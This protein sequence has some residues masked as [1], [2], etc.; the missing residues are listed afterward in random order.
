[1]RRPMRFAVLALLIPYWGVSLAT[2]QA[3][4]TRPSISEEISPVEELS[5][6]THEGQT[7]LGV[8][9]RPPGQRLFPA[10]VI[11][12]SP[13][14]TEAKDGVVG[15]MNRLKVRAL[16]S[17]TFTRFLAAGYVTVLAQQGRLT[18]DA[19]PVGGPQLA[20][21]DHVKRMSAVDPNSVVVY[22]SSYGGY[23][24]LQVA[25]KIE[26]A[27]I[28]VEEPG[29]FGYDAAMA[30][31]NDP[32]AWFRLLEDPRQFFTPELRRSAQEEFRKISGPLFL[33][34]GGLAAG[35]PPDE[36]VDFHSEFLIPDLKAAGKDVE[37][38][39]YPGQRHCF[40]FF[41][42]AERGV[43]NDGDVAASR[44][45]T[46]MDAF[47]KR[48]L[49]TQPRA[50]DDSLIEHVAIEPV[51]VSSET[52]PERVAI[53]VSS[54]ILAD[55]VGTYELLLL[56]FDLVLTLEDDRLMGEAPGFGKFQLFAE[57]ETDFFSNEINTQWQFVRG[58]DGIVMHVMVRFG[59]NEVT[60]P[61]KSNDG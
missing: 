53:T 2:A 11:I 18:G 54:E 44:F 14:N 37:D 49:P 31:A 27:A 4:V 59:S 42:T 13:Y 19:P 46:D 6:E 33:A 17:P 10:I 23:L 38:I 9:R 26:V 41:A 55:Y 50:V 57:S 36:G 29:G 60:A 3:P 21:V 32:P 8:L 35:A 43:A 48:H 52:V 51:P 16:T 56:G 40:G 30:L 34:Q 1:M 5:A 39:T 28:A 58:D 45:F 15:T 61:R 7:A 22:G 24:A 20:I 25:A 12:S 47:F